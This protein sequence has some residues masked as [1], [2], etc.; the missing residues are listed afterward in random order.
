[1][2]G[3]FSFRKPDVHKHEGSYLENFSVPSSA[4]YEAIE[5]EFSALNIPDIAVSRVLYREGGPH[6]IKREYLRISRERFAY[7]VCAA[8]WGSSFFFS[9]RFTEKTR[10]L[11]VW[12]LIVMLA[13]LAGAFF[14]YW[15][16]LGLV[17][18]ISIFVLNFIAAVVLC[19]YVVDMGW[20]W[21]D[22]LL[23][24]LPVVGTFYE[25]YLRPGGYFRDDTRA[26]FLNLADTI[27]DRQIKAFTTDRGVTLGE[28]KDLK[29]EGK[30]AAFMRRMLKA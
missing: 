27:V 10:N 4:L 5:G 24:R 21:F 9:K 12:E 3:M 19:R 15:H 26:L 7:I 16:L 8:P 30:L 2:F 29:Q 23:L 6:T 14:A 1:M 22:D 20:D 28:F 17:W 13:F 11:R 25:L 18:G